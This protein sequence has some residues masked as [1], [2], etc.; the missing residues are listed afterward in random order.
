MF[1]I[2]HSDD[3]MFGDMFWP[4][5]LNNQRITITPFTSLNTL[6]TVMSYIHYREIRFI[7]KE[8]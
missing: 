2:P 4:I 1:V 6:C 5:F 3:V 8:A 7:V